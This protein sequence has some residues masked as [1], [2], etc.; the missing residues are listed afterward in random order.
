MAYYKFNKQELLKLPIHLVCLLKQLI[1]AMLC[2]THPPIT[3]LIP[4]AIRN[5]PALAVKIM[6]HAS[7]H[8]NTMFNDSLLQPHRVQ[9]LTASD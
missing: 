6:N 7:I 9:C 8:G 1:V 3:N 2:N 4:F 5:R